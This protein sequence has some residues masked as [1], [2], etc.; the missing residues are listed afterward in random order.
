MQFSAAKVALRVAD[1]L[2]QLKNFNILPVSKS[3][4]IYYRIYRLFSLVLLTFCLWPSIKIL[5]SLVPFPWKEMKKHKM[6]NWYFTYFTLPLIL[7]VGLSH[8]QLQV[9]QVQA[10]SQDCPFL[11]QTFFGFDFYQ[12]YQIICHDFLPWFQHFVRLLILIKI[13]PEPISNLTT[14]FEQLQTAIMWQ[15]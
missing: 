15:S 13:F 3:L 10:H 1:Y 5:A 9:C 12:I 4:N 14:L 6:L 7:A 11:L 8:F 2:S